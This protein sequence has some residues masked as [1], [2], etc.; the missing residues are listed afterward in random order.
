MIYLPLY[1]YIDINKG[2]LSVHGGSL[3]VFHC[4]EVQ[5][6]L[7]SCHSSFCRDILLPLCHSERNASSAIEDISALYEFMVLYSLPIHRVGYGFTIS[8][9][10]CETRNCQLSTVVFQTLKSANNLTLFLP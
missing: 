4:E 3:A 10:A 2:F 6:L 1:A 9:T 8:L 5:D 7:L